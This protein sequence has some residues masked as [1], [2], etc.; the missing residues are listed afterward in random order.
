[1]ALSKKNK[2]I[3][4]IGFLIGII[5]LF[6]LVKES[7]RVLEETVSPEPPAGFKN[8]KTITKGKDNM[9]FDLVIE[10]PVIYHFFIAPNFNGNKIVK[11]KGEKRFIGLFTNEITL[12]EGDYGNSQIALILVPG[13]Y[14]FSVD[15]EINGASIYFYTNVYEMD[16]TYFR[17]ISLI[18]SGKIYN[19]PANYKELFRTNLT[20]LNLNNLTIAKFS[21]EKSGE[22][23]FSVY[24][25]KSS[26]KF[27]VRLVGGGYKGV[28]LLNETRLF[29][30]QLSLYLPRGNYEL[31]LSSYE[32]KA[33][34]V[35]YMTN[36]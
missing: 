19:P 10:K 18:D 26:G 1:M 13:V 7:I 21:I 20:R 27:S 17:R 12:L 5:L 15:F 22:Y 34:I 31:L 36:F 2:K 14:N 3:F 9:S 32:S 30:D 11:L 33:D 4:S 16:D 29:S 23:G 24:S 25:T 8:Y 35:V 6:I 28:D